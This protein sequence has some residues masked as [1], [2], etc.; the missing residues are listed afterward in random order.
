MTLMRTSPMTRDNR[1]EAIRSN[2]A[3]KAV[4]SCESRN[5]PGRRKADLGRESAAVWMG[6][7]VRCVS[8]AMDCLGSILSILSLRQWIDVDQPVCLSHDANAQI[9]KV[10]R[11][12][13][14]RDT[15]HSHRGA[16]R[17]SSIVCRQNARS[18]HGLSVSSC[19]PGRAAYKRHKSRRMRIVWPATP[20]RR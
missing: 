11:H 19:L 3:E 10:F 13:G 18:A 6:S 17:V 8:S 16:T 7:G 1:T 4:C 20:T 14:C 5:Q 2:M 15:N 12:T 9:T